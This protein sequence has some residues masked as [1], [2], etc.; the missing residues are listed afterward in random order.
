MSVKLRKNK[1][2]SSIGKMQKQMPK[3]PQLAFKFWRKITP[4]DTGNAKRKTVLRGNTINARYPY[5]ERLDNGWSKQAP[6]GMYIP[7]LEYL[8]K[9]LKGKVIRK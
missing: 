1:L 9:I 2:K 5:A 8:K 6:K 4:K 3:L 7:T